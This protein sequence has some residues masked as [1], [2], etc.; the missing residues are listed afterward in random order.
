[1]VSS[2]DCR[3]RRK[4]Q[5]AGLYGRRMIVAEVRRADLPT[6]SPGAVNCAMRTLGLSRVV[7]TTD[8]YMTAHG[9]GVVRA[10]DM[11]DRGFNS[12]RLDR[13]GLRR[14]F[15]VHPHRRQRHRSRPGHKD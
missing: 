6:A 1:M 4:T 7:R 15:V 3:S 14:R 2:R 12:G 5:L 13:R 10:L 9:P 11:V 8:V